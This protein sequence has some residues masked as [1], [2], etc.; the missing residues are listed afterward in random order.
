M[1][2]ITTDKVTFIGYFSTPQRIIFGSKEGYVTIYNLA[3]R[4]KQSFSISN[5]TRQG[6]KKVI[7]VIE[8][9]SKVADARKH[10]YY[11]LTQGNLYV[12]SKENREIIQVFYKGDRAVHNRPRLL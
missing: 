4:E 6:M 2:D 11:I 5:E 3:K 10:I 7:S 1:D 12:M 8:L 9:P